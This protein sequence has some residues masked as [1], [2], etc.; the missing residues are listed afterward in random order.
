MKTEAKILDVTCGSRMMWFNKNHSDCIYMDIRK[1]EIP[2]SDGTFL[3]IN[4]DII[5]DFTQIPFEENRFQLVVFDPPHSKWLGKNTIMGQRYGQLLPTWETDIRAGFN[6]CF[7]V[8][9]P[10]GILIFK[11]HTKDISLNKLLSVIDYT[12]LFGHTSSKHGKTI[13]LT[14]MKLV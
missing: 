4:P 2:Q 8:L 12:P 11:W 3:S 5:G 7:R 13:W 9:K 1:E 10:N 14:F 6:E